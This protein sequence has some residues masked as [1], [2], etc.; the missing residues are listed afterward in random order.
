MQLGL[1]SDVS[2]RNFAGAQDPDG[3]LYVHFLIM[4][5]QN[6][7]KTD[8]EKRPV[9]EDVV[10]VEITTPGIVP[11]TICRPMVPNDKARF[12]KHWAFFQNAHGAD[13]QTVGTPLTQWPRMSPSQ[14]E[15]LKAVGFRTVDSIAMASDQ[16][17][18]AI[19]MAG[20]M[21]PVSLRDA[22]RL[23]LKSAEG[24]SAAAELKA[25]NDAKD[26][27]I[28]DMAEKHAA[29]IARLE[30]LILAKSERKKPG[31]KP[32]VEPVGP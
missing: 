12:P 18:Q 7:F 4:P 28:A 27:I 26:K 10:M 23:F 17:I 1:E 19:G 9:F 22:A 14:V 21:A 31:R 24:D 8:K 30:A 5:I 6:N 2:N 3:A 11:N 32:K 13:G 29:D 25:Q 20:G 15:M 16:Q